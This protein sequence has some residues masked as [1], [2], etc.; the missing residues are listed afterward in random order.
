MFSNYLNVFTAKKK[1]KSPD[2]VNG[3][4]EDAFLLGYILLTQLIKD[5]GISFLHQNHYIFASKALLPIM[6]KITLNYVF[7]FL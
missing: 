1:K 7:F 5:T 3:K 4:A 2:L 6:E